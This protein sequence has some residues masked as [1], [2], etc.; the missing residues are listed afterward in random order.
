MATEGN[1]SQAA[2][3]AA[4]SDVLVNM[5][6]RIATILHLQQVQQKR[7]VSQLM[8]SHPVTNA[9]AEFRRGLEELV[10]DHLNT[11]MAIASCSTAHDAAGSN[12]LSRTQSCSS[13]HEESASSHSNQHQ[14]S[15]TEEAGDGN[16]A[17]STQSV[18]SGDHHNNQFA[19]AVDVEVQ[20]HGEQADGVQ[21]SG[22]HLRSRESGGTNH[23]PSRLQSRI[24]DR[25]DDRQ[26]Q[27]MITNMERQAR[28]SELLALAS[29][30]T[31]TM[32]DASFLQE[33]ASPR[34]AA[35][36]FERPQR[37]A[38]SL[39]QMWRDLEGDDQDSDRPH[40]TEL[41]ENGT[42]PGISRL[43]VPEEDQHDE[44]MS[45]EEQLEIIAAGGSD[46]PDQR[47][48]PGD[49][50]QQ[51]GSE[52]AESAPHEENHM[53]DGSAPFGNAERDR[54]RQV[55]QRWMAQARV[56]N[57]STSP[58]YSPSTGDESLGQV[59]R[60]RSRQWDWGGASSQHSTASQQ[61]GRG[62][63]LQ[64][65]TYSEVDRE[66]MNIGLRSQRDM[67][68]GLDLLMRSDME[69]QSELQGLSQHRAVSAFPHRS[70]LQVLLHLLTR[71]NL[72]AS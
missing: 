49:L 63:S 50:G 40:T 45:E 38:S 23:S 65:Q 46:V 59:E 14:V 2:G 22:R 3:T 60:E 56:A 24:L 28:E 43:I 26:T 25:W 66:S 35:N 61:Q 62:S 12:S 54:V 29:L 58:S 37:R 41:V 27:D 69:R 16:P 10:R 55:M 4:D 33:S 13:V 17:N 21:G 51:W 20:Q 44:D 7:E 9:D 48:E 11:C 19:L 8:E 42:S 30:H 70:R 71:L 1:I 18:T 15:L 39:L 68:M 57:T 36:V 47:A 52:E 6:E 67:Q 32:L 31:V 72:M 5:D 34:S 64:F 53:D